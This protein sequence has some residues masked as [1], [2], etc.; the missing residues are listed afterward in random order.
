MNTISAVSWCRHKRKGRRQCRI[1]GIHTIAGPGVNVI[2]APNNPDGDVGHI[3]FR[4]PSIRP[5]RRV[6]GSCEDGHSFL[7]IQG[8]GSH[9]NIE[10]Q[11]F[12]KHRRSRTIFQQQVAKVRSIRCRRRYSKDELH[13]KSQSRIEVIVDKLALLVRFL[14]VPMI[15]VDRANDRLID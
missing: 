12:R 13:G 7:Q 5:A 6:G 15:L 1:I 3:V 8:R 4:P 9:T 14:G 10:P 2:G 11:Q